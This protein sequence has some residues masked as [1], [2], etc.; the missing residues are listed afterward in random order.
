MKEDDRMTLTLGVT[1]D[2]F[3]DLAAQSWIELMAAYGVELTTSDTRWDERAEEVKLFGVI[4]FSGK[5]VRATCLIGAEHSL[6]E[7]SCRVSSRPRDWIAELA[8][9]LIGRVKMKLLGHGVSVTMT[10]PLALSGV[11]VT[12]LPRLGEDPVA[13]TSPR[14]AA[15]L[16]LEVETDDGFMLGPARPLSVEPGDLVF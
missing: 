5:G 16:W 10:T 1:S 7:A 8:N 6:V 2:F 4:G 3:T 13:F 14:G 15:L 11:R 9:Q 12:P